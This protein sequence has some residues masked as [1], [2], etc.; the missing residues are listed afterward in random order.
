MS[1]ALII[2]DI[3]EDYFKGGACELVN[4][5]Q[6]SLEAKKLLAI[7]REKRLPIF[8]IQ[9]I[10]SIRPNATFL[11]PNTKGIDI[12]E[13]VRPRNDEPVIQKNF[14][15]S[16]LQTNLEDALEKLGVKD[17]V[18]CGMMSHMCVDATTRAAF[19]LGFNC[20]VAHDACTTKDI[21]FHDVDIKQKDVH[22]AFMSALGAVYAQMKM[23][24]EIINALE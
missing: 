21:Q 7:F 10:N 14:P 4:P 17:L 12:H 22:N 8:H 18:I 24:D 13:N 11:L 3:Q 16:F 6:T 15:N 20:T 1:K 9:H 2:I 5:L 23:S 19:D